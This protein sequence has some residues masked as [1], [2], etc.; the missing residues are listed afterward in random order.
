LGGHRNVG[1]ERGS[2]K[3]GEDR[4]GGKTGCARLNWAASTKKTVPTSHA[5]SEH[6]QLRGEEKK[7]PKCQSK[8]G[9]EGKE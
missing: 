8:K 1:R 4:K 2:K 3:G 7:V 6:D 5:S 9:G